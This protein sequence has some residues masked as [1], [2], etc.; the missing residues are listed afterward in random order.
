MFQGKSVH[1]G[2]APEVS[3]LDKAETMSFFRNLDDWAQ[4]E[5]DARRLLQELD[6]RKPRTFIM[7]TE[8]KQRP[9]NAPAL[10]GRAED[11]A[12]ARRK[13]ESQKRVLPHASGIAGNSV[14]RK[15]RE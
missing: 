11:K 1:Y 5:N 7:G 10:R 15:F 9:A 2:N 12:P 6:A 4:M 13:E 14:R 8:I 3:P